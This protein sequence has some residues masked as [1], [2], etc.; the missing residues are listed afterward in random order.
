VGVV[1][2][3]FLTVPYVVARTDFTFEGPLI[4]LRRFMMDSQFQFRILPMPEESG[5]FEP[6]LVWHHCSH[7]DPF[8]Q[9]VRGLVVDAARSEARLLGVI[10]TS[11]E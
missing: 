6:R 1:L 11:E 10:D 7:T 5:P 3:Y 9:W 8:L 2:P 4:T